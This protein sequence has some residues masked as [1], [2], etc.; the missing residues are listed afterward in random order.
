VGAAPCSVASLARL[1]APGPLVYETGKQ[2]RLDDLEGMDGG[3][4]GLEVKA[5]LAA[6]NAAL[7]VVLG[8]LTPGP[9]VGLAV[10]SEQRASTEA[11][12]AGRSPTAPWASGPPSRTSHRP[13][14]SRGAGNIG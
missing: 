12:G 6:T 7:R 1:K 11:G 5:G 3:A 4:D 2:R 9:Q 10:Q 14:P 8:A 13:P